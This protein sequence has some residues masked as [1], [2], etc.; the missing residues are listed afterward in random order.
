MEKCMY[1][2]IH[3]YDAKKK[4]VKSTSK[5]KKKKLTQLHCMSG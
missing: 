5:Q 3:I 2:D 4:E 1:M